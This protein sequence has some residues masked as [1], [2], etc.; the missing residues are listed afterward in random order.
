M[1]WSGQ[2]FPVRPLVSAVLL[3]SACGG[4]EET[5]RPEQQDQAQQGQSAQDPARQDGR[6]QAVAGTDSCAPDQDLPGY[7]HGL[8]QTK[9]DFGGEPVLEVD[10]ALKRWRGPNGAFAVFDNGN[11]MAVPDAGKL[12]GALSESGEMQA[13]RVQDYFTQ[14]GLPACQVAGRQALGGSSGTSGSLSRAIDG[15]RIAESQAHA[16]FIRDDATSSESVYWPTLPRAVVDAA[17]RFREAL[18]DAQALSEYRA[19]LPS[20][21]TGPGAVVIHHAASSGLFQPFWARVTYD[22]E[23][24]PPFSGRSTRHFDADGRELT[25]F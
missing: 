3:A 23:P 22:V 17:R 13:L 7:A 6:A 1:P 20:D 5:G 11:A 21:A 8:T 12:N 25:G 19:K 2:R 9:F 14:A 18:A 16:R 10:G 24:T 4:V 15:I